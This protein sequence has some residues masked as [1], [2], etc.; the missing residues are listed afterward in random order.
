MTMVKKIRT[1][2]KVKR[3]HTQPRIHEDSVGLH[4]ANV[5]AL[6]LVF[7]PDCRKEVLVEALMHDVAEVETGDTPATV[8]NWEELRVALEYLE[9]RFRANNLIPTPKLTKEEQGLLH[10]V[11]RLESLIS[12]QEEFNMGNKYASVITDNAW[13]MLVSM[14]VPPYYYDLALAIWEEHKFLEDL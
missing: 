4:S 1:G 14:D 2:Y 10:F 8:K 12:A 9:A 7:D 3:F 13:S 5:A 6:V 11:D